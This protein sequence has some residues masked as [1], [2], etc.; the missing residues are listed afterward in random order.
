[1]D[2]FEGIRRKESPK[3]KLALAAHVLAALAKA[4]HRGQT[5]SL[6]DLVKEIEVR[7]ADVRACLSSLHAEGFVDCVRMRLTLR[8]FAL[9]SA[10]AGRKLMPLRLLASVA[11]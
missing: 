11:A 4:Q 2:S 1:M 3:Q 8:G 9:G 5:M 10:L 7:R 6:E